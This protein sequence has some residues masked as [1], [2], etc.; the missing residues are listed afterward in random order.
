MNKNTLFLTDAGLIKLDEFNEPIGVHSDRTAISRVVK[1]NE[2]THIVYNKNNRRIQL[3]AEEGDILIEFY[4]GSFTNP[5][6]LIH[7]KEWVENLEKYEKVQQ[8]AKEKWAA[9]NACDSCDA[10]GK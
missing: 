6:I 8:E 5:I 10:I 3:E 9:A 7:S 4:E 2:P 1:I